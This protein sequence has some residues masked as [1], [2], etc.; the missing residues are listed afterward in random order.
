MDIDRNARDIIERV[1]LLTKDFDETT[2]YDYYGHFNK[3]TLGAMLF[4]KVED[5]S[6]LTEQ[7][8]T[9]RREF[10]RLES[11]RNACIEPRSVSVPRVAAIKLNVSFINM[12]II[13]CVLFT[14]GT[15]VRTII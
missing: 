12:L 3:S 13:F 7:N 9:L 8:E 1:N 15:I 6:L 14:F 11:A 5:N 10:A 4:A 2:F